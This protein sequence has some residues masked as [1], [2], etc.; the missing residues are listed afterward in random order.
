MLIFLFDSRLSYWRNVRKFSCKYLIEV[1]NETNK[2][3]LF[4]LHIDNKNCTTVYHILSR[5][6]I[7]ARIYFSDTI[8]KT[9]FLNVSISERVSSWPAL[10]NR[11]N[12]P[13]TPES[14]RFLWVSSPHFIGTNSSAVPWNCKRGGFRVSGCSR[15][16]Y[17]RNG[18]V[19]KMK[20][21]ML[22]EIRDIRTL[23]TDEF[24]LRKLDMAKHPAK[25]GLCLYVKYKD[26]APP[27]EKPPTMILLCG[28]PLVTSASISSD[29][30]P[31]ID[32]IDSTSSG[33]FMD[34]FLRSNHTQLG[35]NN[36]CA[37]SLLRVSNSVH[38]IPMLPF[39]YKPYMVAEVQRDT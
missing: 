24:L 31:H 3:D 23:Y 12:W 26:S 37:L 28:I 29:T 19:N 18:V 1:C 6:I 20:R 10:F 21:R 9:H 15:K 16:C 22:R 36:S 17:N 25:D 11:T 32:S 4:N 27:I 14:V 13:F 5:R 7:V 39:H 33:T 30:L 35:C 8:S 2:I 38:H 34:T